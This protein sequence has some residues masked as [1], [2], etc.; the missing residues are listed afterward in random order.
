MAS[1]PP[2]SPAISNSSTDSQSAPEGPL[3]SAPRSRDMKPPRLRS[4]PAEKSPG[5]SSASEEDGSI[6]GSVSAGLTGPADSA[7]SAGST[8]QTDSTGSLDSVA[9]VFDSSFGLRRRNRGNLPV[10]RPLPLPASWS[11]DPPDRAL[12]QA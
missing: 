2:M 11:L 8:L 5:V 9:G 4:R 10:S 1:P 6:E 3:L 12:P 7:A